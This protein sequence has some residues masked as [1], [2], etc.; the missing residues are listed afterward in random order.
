MEVSLVARYKNSGTLGDRLK[1]AVLQHLGLMSRGT[2]M[3]GRDRNHTPS[4]S[5]HVC[6]CGVELSGVRD[7]KAA[8]ELRPHQRARERKGSSRRHEQTPKVLTALTSR[9]SIIAPLRIGHLSGGLHSTRS[10]ADH[11][12]PVWKLSCLP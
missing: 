7:L 10:S 4:A 2:H 12:S 1:V 8:S 6:V 3:I 11:P 9:L 5:R